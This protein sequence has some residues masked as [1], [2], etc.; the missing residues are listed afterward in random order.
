MDFE[1]DNN[2]LEEN[3][4]K[5][6]VDFLKAMLIFESA[7]STLEDKRK[8]YGEQRFVSIGMVGKDCI[9]V[10]HTPRGEKTR[11]IS[12]W[13]GGS[14]EERKYRDYVARRGA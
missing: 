12:A 14:D 4:E 7:V 5:H 11:L 8:D 10:V 1:W 13:N 6:G 2:K 9:V 3:L